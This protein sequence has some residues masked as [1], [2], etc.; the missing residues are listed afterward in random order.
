MERY[1]GAERAESVV[2]LAC[3]LA[4]AAVSAG[5]VALR[6]PY[7]AMAWLTPGLIQLVGGNGLPAHARAEELLARQLRASPSAYRA[8]ETT[9]MR[10][11]QRRFVP[12]KRLEIGLLALGLAL[13]SV[14][15]YGR[16]LYAV[17]L[18][19]MLEA[20]LMLALASGAR[21]PLRPFRLETP[22]GLHATAVN[23]GSFLG[24]LRAER[25]GQRYL[26]MVKGLG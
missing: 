23:C 16:T 12:Y 4:A 17:G 24:D 6:S 25:R 9:R 15:G 7:R 18:G 5:L 26:E 22:R 19:L 21:K 10:R 20:S 13:A 3:A 2:F 1:F 14:E 8:E 11:V